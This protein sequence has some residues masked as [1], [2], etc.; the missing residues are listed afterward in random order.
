LWVA[1]VEAGETEGAGTDYFLHKD[2]APLF[3]RQA[4][5]PSR[6]LLACTHYPLLLSRLRT[7]IPAGVDILTQ[8]PL[9]AER[10]E[11]WLRRHPEMERRLGRNG[12]WQ[13]LTTDE[14]AWFTAFGERVLDAS[15]PAIKIQLQ[16]FLSR[17]FR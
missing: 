11:D 10:F 15:C 13:L 1:L 6:I 3:E 4:D 5:Q 17:P 2:I 14:P 9:I 8:G 7:L 16:P 12:D